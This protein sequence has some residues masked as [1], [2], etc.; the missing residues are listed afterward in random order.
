MEEKDINGIA[1]AVSAA[2][3]KLNADTKEK[4]G[5]KNVSEKN[6]KKR[7]NL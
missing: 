4:E 7:F 2:I 5:E 6:G 1:A 3:G